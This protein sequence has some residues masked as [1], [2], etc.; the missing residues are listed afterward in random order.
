MKQRIVLLTGASSGI[1]VEIA[2]QLHR[3]GDIPI[4]VARNRDALNSL[5]AELTDSVSYVCDVRDNQQIQDM[6]AQVITRFGQIDVLINNAGYGHFGLPLEI[7]LEDYRGMMETNY[8]GAVQMSLAVLPTMLSQQQGVILNIASYA[9]LTGVP[10]LA[11]YAASKAA[12][13]SFTHSLALAYE[14]TIGIGALCPGPVQTPFFGDRSLEEQFPPL[15]AQQSLT[16]EQ[17]AAEAINLLGHPQIK[18]IPRTLDW[19]H[20]CSRWAPRLSRR[21]TGQLYQS[22]L[23][24]K[25]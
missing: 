17:V 7:P 12:L 1:G 2:R 8:L 23:Q 5:R 4:L 15:I 22:F 14:P 6:V 16:A 9:A 20:R 11:G 13:L 10:N 25:E 3:Q 21:I 18:V 19:V 24:K